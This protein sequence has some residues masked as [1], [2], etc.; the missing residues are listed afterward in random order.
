MDGHDMSLDMLGGGG[1]MPSLATSMGDPTYTTMSMYQVCLSIYLFVYL[2]KLV[3]FSDHLL[4]Y[5]NIYLS[6]YL[7]IHLFIHLLIIFPSIYLSI[8][9]FS[10]HPSIYQS[11]RF[12]FLHLFINL[13]NFFPSIYLWIYWFLSIHLFIHLFILFPS[14]DLCVYLIDLV[15]L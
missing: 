2:T 9:S 15:W 1:G 11:T 13:L 14:I 5:K 10:F 3:I 4:I 7:S 12:L 6:I 8:Y